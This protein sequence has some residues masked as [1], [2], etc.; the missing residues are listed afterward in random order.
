MTKKDLKNGMIVKVRDG[1]MYLMHD[2]KLLNSNKN[3]HNGIENFN[4]DLLSKYGRG[5]DVMGVYKSNAY[6]LDRLFDECYLETIWEREQLPRYG[7]KVV[8]VDT[9]EAHTTNIQW[10]EKHE[11]NFDLNTLLKFKYAQRPSINYEYVVIYVDPKEKKV[12][13]GCELSVYLMSMR[14]VKVVNG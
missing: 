14:G 4:D 5:F 7:D 1:E 11:D 13:I 8:V 9:D 3:T 2:S 12:L 10:F 6:S